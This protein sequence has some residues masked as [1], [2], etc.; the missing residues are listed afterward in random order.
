MLSVSQIKYLLDVGRIAYQHVGDIPI[1]FVP[2]SETIDI[3]IPYEEFRR[4]MGI[5]DLRFQWLCSYNSIIAGG[6]AL[7]WVWGESKNGDTDFFF[8]NDESREMF[9][10]LIEGFGF[11]RTNITGY[12]D[13]YFC[14][15]NNAIVQLVNTWSIVHR[16]KD[17]VYSKP[18]T[19][20]MIIDTF[21]INVC[22]FA[23][24]CD[25]VYT[26]SKAI[27]D[28]LSLSISG[29]SKTSDAAFSQRLYKYSRKG[30]FIDDGLR[31]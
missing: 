16:N 28:L 10:A 20:K 23:A 26:N 27:E 13:T 8:T 3:A 4:S 7:N 12:A 1:S 11:T 9:S 14:K 29:V 15:E 24:D 30:L 6:A 17:I 21:D 22:K 19:A 25:L 31:K 18:I 2:R 5:A